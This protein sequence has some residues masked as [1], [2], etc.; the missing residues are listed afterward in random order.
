MK[1]PTRSWSWHEVD[2]GLQPQHRVVVVGVDDRVDLQD[3]RPRAQRHDEKRARSGW[4][5]SAVER[6]PGCPGRRARPPRRPEHPR[7]SSPSRTK[8]EFGSRIT[9]GSCVCSSTCSRSD[10]ERIGLA[11]AAL[12]APEGVPVQSCDASSCAGVASSDS[13]QGA[14]GQVAGHVRML[15]AMRAR[16]S[17]RRRLRSWWRMTSATTKLNHFCGELGVEVGIEREA[18]AGGRPAAPRGRGRM[19]ASRARPSARRPASSHG[20]ARRAGT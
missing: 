12:P 7:G 10:T 3:R 11:G 19:P 17:V 5:A 13:E 8:S 2:L 1:C 18:S 15:P 16:L 14:D 20:S 9:S 6:R 4:S